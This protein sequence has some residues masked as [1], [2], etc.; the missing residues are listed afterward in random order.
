MTP[1][2]ASLP[3]RTSAS[4]CARAPPPPRAAPTSAASR[5]ARWTRVGV[6]DASCL[7]WRH[8]SCPT[9]RSA[10]DGDGS[11]TPSVGCRVFGAVSKAK[12]PPARPLRWPL[13]RR[14]TAAMT[15]DST[16]ARSRRYGARGSSRIDDPANDDPDDDDAD[17][18]DE[19]DDDDDDFVAVAAQV[20]ATA[21]H[22]SRTS[23]VARSSSIASGVVDPLRRRDFATRRNP[24]ANAR[25]RRTRTRTTIRGMRASPRGDRRPRWRWR[26]TRTATNA[27]A[28]RASW[29]R[30][31][32]SR[33]CRAIGPSRSREPR[34][35][36]RLR[37]TRRRRH[38]R[39][40]A[41]SDCARR[42]GDGSR[43]AR[44]PSPNGPRRRATRERSGPMG[45]RARCRRGRRRGG[46]WRG[47]P[48]RAR[49]WRARSIWVA[50]RAL[51]K[52]HVGQVRETHGFTQGESNK[53]FSVATDE[54][55]RAS[56]RAGEMT[57]GGKR[58]RERSMDA[59]EPPTN[60][61][62]PLMDLM[63]HAPDVFHEGITSRLEYG[64]LF[65]LAAASAVCRDEV[66]SLD[67]VRP[68]EIRQERVP[69]ISL[70]LLGATAGERS[71]DTFQLG[72]VVPRKLVPRLGR[73]TCRSNNT[74]PPPPQRHR[75]RRE[76]RAS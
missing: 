46:G 28:T 56:A 11:S 15:S 5:P 68:R 26:W 24:G 51:T 14:A 38:P 19:Y 64:D 23:R 50:P 76:P 75:V 49:G 53:T 8:V 21:A 17:D 73:R 48:S 33:R 13:R 31:R 71:R 69:S 27:P 37:S 41:P 60:G 45:T 44:A 16:A 59:S 6:V 74:I 58:A 25:R 62:S 2:P 10:F 57:S 30:P 29:T 22:A 3:P 54:G 61:S 34:P 18:L 70:G 52:T 1:N 66:R 72:V 7:F 63:L 35:G 12:P 4:P 39:G 47:I 67:D 32:C 9:V 20:A 42:G 43:S 65:S 40:G 55:C 36:R